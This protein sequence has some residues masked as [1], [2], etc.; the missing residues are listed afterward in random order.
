MVVYDLPSTHLD[1]GQIRNRGVDSQRHRGHARRIGIELALRRVLDQS[2]LHAVERIAFL[3]DRFGQHSKLL[4]LDRA[5]T[6]S[7]QL[8]SPD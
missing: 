1:P 3:V 8:I 2:V 7:R 4:T 5:R 6:V